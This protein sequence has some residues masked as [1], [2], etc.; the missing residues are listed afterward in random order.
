M[1]H[2]VLAYIQDNREDLIKKIA[3]RTNNID[4][5]EDVLS[6][7]ILNVIRWVKP[8][9]EEKLIPPYVGKGLLHATHNFY[10]K[11]DKGEI[12]DD[13]EQELSPLTF[14]QLF[15]RQID[16]ARNPLHI[17]LEEDIISRVPQLIEENVTNT[18][19]QELLHL[20]FVNYTDPKVAQDLTG[21]STKWRQRIVAKFLSDIGEEYE[22]L[23]S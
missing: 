7:Y 23:R 12:V 4:D 20:I 2:T 10:R 17:L 16:E 13:E 1:E 8:D 11:K 5:A 18:V 15:D 22:N 3:S 9:I 6:D 19:H 21:I 14:Y